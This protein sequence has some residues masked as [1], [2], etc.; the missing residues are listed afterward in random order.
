MRGIIGDVRSLFAELFM[1]L[2]THL[3][4]KVGGALRRRYWR[5]RLGKFG[6]GVTIET[7][8]HF[9]CP[10]LIFIDNDT[11]IGHGATLLAGKPAPGSARIIRGRRTVEE[12]HVYIGKRVHVLAYATLS[13]MGGLRVGDNSH[14]GSKASVYSYTQVKL[15]PN[16][17]Y[18]ASIDIGS[19]VVIGTNASV[20][21][22]GEIADGTVI[23]PN[24]FV[25]EVLIKSHHRV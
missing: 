20:I 16:V 8:V 22:A 7:G 5:R 18:V 23:R 15:Q 24:S 25:S 1:L 17:V 19:N 10:H 6:N 21:C 11:L 2:V 3:P 9:Q 14:I 12:G 13:G 4:G